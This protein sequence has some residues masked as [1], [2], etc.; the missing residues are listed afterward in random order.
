ME[1]QPP[2]QSSASAPEP[3]A[4][5]ATKVRAPGWLPRLD[6]DGR[7]ECIEH[8]GQGATPDLSYYVLLILSTLIA[9]YGLLSNSTATVIG[10]MIVAPLMGPILGLAM[11]MV[12]G[13]SKM[14]RHSLFAEVSGVALVILTGA[15]VAQ[16]AGIDSIDF[17]AAEIAN[18]TRPTLYDMAIGLAAGLA[19]S[20]CLIHPGL[21][22]SVAGVAIAVALVPPLAVTGI[23]L[24]GWWSGQIGKSAAFG[25]FMLF[26]ANFLTIELAAGVLFYLSGFRLQQRGRERGAFRR[27]ILVQLLLLLVTAGFLYG[28]LRGLVQE[29]A[30]RNLARQAMKAVLRDI[31]GAELDSLEVQLQGQTHFVQAVVGSRTEITPEMVS[32]M[33]ADLAAALKGRFRAPDVQLV[34]RTVSSTYA[35]S[36]GFLFEPQGVPPSPEQ[37]RS[38]MLERHLR[39]ILA[40]FPGVELSGFRPLPSEFG[41]TDAQGIGDIEKPWPVEVTLRS[42]YDFQPR[43]VS[44][45]ESRLNEALGANEAF[46]GRPVRL[47]VRTVAVASST[48]SS[49]VAISAPGKEEVVENAELNRLLATA[50]SEAG[51]QVVRLSSRPLD[52]PELPLEASPRYLAQA[53]IRGPKLLEEQQARRLRDQVRQSYQEQTGQPIELELELES[54]LARQISIGSSQDSNSGDR[55][56]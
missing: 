38:Q 26:L 3:P 36:S 21:R 35:S 15:V 55:T 11:G 56:P 9:A 47:L 44:E 5:S 37:V 42:P 33:E 10:A 22:S 32:R 7:H 13:D 16:L 40:Q 45:L 1:S 14:F 34:V 19:G 18:R 41:S 51:Q 49:T 30:G 43:L 24:S 8:I 48:A 28:Q 39:G 25:S 53:R 52:P 27:A 2:Q 4:V 20:Y 50:L 6:P 54:E 23:T 46:E 29:R 12:I 17:T 31:P